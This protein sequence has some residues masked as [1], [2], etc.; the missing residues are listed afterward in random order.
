MMQIKRRIY[1]RSFFACAAPRPLFIFRRMSTPPPNDPI[2]DYVNQAAGL[3]N[4][5]IRPEHY[6]EVLL[7][8][9]ALRAQ[10]EI[11][12]EFTLPAEIEA[13]RFTP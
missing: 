5:P 11:V 8:F 4:L 13:A 3:L 7:A 12:S 6:E 10:A 2:A 1:F 9:R